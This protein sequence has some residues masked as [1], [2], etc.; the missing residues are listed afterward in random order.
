MRRDSSYR[1]G[2][3][4]MTEPG[5]AALIAAY[6]VLNTPSIFAVPISLSTKRIVY[7]YSELIRPCKLLPVP[8][9]GLLKPLPLRVPF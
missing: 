9:V 2:L 1:P 7:G 8:F 3:I 5:A 4:L 6:I